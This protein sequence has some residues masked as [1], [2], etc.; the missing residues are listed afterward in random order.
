MELSEYQAKA[1]Q[2]SGNVNIGHLMVYPAL[3]LSNETGE[4]LGKVKK[5]FRDGEWNEGLV[6]K[7][8]GDIL[9]YLSEFCT[10]MGWDMDQIAEMNLDKLARR[11]A[12]GKIH[13]SGDE[14]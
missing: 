6:K 5:Y 7:E 11:Q 4:L 9:W 10:V 1:H 12:E 13:G 14:R 2:T 3:G 8:L